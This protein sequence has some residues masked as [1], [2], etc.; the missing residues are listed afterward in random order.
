MP[1]FP[2]N[3]KPPVSQARLDAWSLSAA[4]LCVLALFFDF[5][6]WVLAVAG[7]VLLRRAAFSRTVKWYLAAIA[8]APKIL[9]FGVRS[10][11]APGGLSFAIEP[12]NLATSS[13]LWAWCIFLMAFGGYLLLQ[14]RRPP[15]EAHAPVQPGSYRSLMIGGLG[16][17]AIAA[18]VVLLLGVM[19][20]FHWINE[21]GRGQWALRHAVRGNVATFTGSDVRSI[22][23]T[24]RYS[25]RGGSSYSVRVALADGR[26]F[27][28]S[29]KSAAALDELRKFSTTANLTGGKVRI[30][31]HRGALW[32]NGSSGFRLPDCVGT[33]EAVDAGEA[34]STYEFWLDGERLAG[35]ETLVETPGRHVRMLRNIKVGET[36]E[37]EFEGSPYVDAARPDQG[38]LAVSF[39]WSSKGETGRFVKN[40]LEIG[41]QKYRKL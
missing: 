20:G 36:G 17:A 33:Y 32:T 22:D 40:G 23:A 39:G 41:L 15:Q 7:I 13:S 16:V 19:D 5:F 29:T 21:A 26:S 11:A 38:K 18:A 30:V 3:P 27:A 6:G 10:L 14:A 25:Q 9:F 35:K 2:D 1:E 8:I 4:S 12:R 37:F 31:H 24:E 28:V 34:R